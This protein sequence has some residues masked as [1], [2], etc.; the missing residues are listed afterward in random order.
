MLVNTQKWIKY[1]S[2]YLGAVIRPN[3]WLCFDPTYWIF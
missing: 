1:L 2:E 3:G